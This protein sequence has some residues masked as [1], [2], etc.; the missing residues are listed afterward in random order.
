MR[1]LGSLVLC[2]IMIGAFS[3]FAEGKKEGAAAPEA[4]EYLIRVTHV[5]T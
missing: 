2:L 3:L 4:K 1:K 5:A